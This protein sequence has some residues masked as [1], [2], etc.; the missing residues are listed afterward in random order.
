[1]GINVNNIKLQCEL[2][3]DNSKKKMQ[4]TKMH[5][6]NSQNFQRKIRI[7]GREN[8]SEFYCFLNIRELVEFMQ[9]LIVRRTMR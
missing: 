8:L 2:K 6:K 4:N 5:L 7:F 9:T 3:G 1:V